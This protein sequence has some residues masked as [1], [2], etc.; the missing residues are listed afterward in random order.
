[1]SPLSEQPF[2]LAAL[3]EDQ[4]SYY[5]QA[6]H[7]SESS[8]EPTSPQPAVGNLEPFPASVPDTAHNVMPAAPD[9]YGFF[10]PLEPSGHA[11][12]VAVPGLFES[13]AESGGQQLEHAAPIVEPPAERPV[14]PTSSAD[15]EVRK[16]I[17]QDLYMDR[18]LILNEVIDIMLKKHNFKATCVCPTP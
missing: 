8:L 12:L 2:A 6:L 13:P 18:N 15:W 3:S 10:E 9:V 17:I 7:H 5:F 16:H 4:Y 14:V 11:P 1:M